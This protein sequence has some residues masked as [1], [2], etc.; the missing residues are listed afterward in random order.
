MNGDLE[1][2][3]RAVRESVD[4]VATFGAADLRTESVRCRRDREPPVG[5]WQTPFTVREERRH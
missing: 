4:A 3:F 1:S 2:A 5:V